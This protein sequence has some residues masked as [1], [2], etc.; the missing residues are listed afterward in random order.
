MAEK[1]FHAA[2]SGRPLRAVKFIERE[3]A[4]AG[5]VHA[6]EQ[7]AFGTKDRKQAPI[8]HGVIVT[9]LFAASAK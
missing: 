2:V 4:W 3:G 9:A 1:I 7:A 6:I 8:A 5:L